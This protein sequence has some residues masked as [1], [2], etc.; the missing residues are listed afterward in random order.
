MGSGRF[1]NEHYS[2]ASYIKQPRMR[3]Y[4]M[5]Y[6]YTE[7][8]V[9]A[10]RLQVLY[11][12]L[13]KMLLSNFMITR[14]KEMV[15]LLALLY[16]ASS[17]GV[18]VGKQSNPFPGE[19]LPVE[20]KLRLLNKPSVKSIQSEDGDIIDCVDLY[21]QPAL[22]HPLLKNHSIR[23]SPSF[24]PTNVDSST[25]SILNYSL[26][27][28]Q[29]WH[30][31]G[32]C[33]DGTIPIR[34]VLK[35][36]LL[37]ASSL[38][39]YGRKNT[40]V[41]TKHDFRMLEHTFAV[42]IEH[43]HTAA[44]LITAG[45]SY[46]GAKADI[47]VWNPRVEADN[48]Y[49]TAQIWLRNG[50][51]N[52]SDTIEFGWIVNPS[53][54]GDRQTRLFIYW[55]NDSGKSTGCFDLL[56]PGFVQVNK[57]ILLGGTIYPT[58]AIHGQQ[59]HISL[60]VVRDFDQNVWWLISRTDNIMIGY[61]PCDIFSY[62]YNI[63]VIVEWGGDVYSP[64]MHQEPH[65]ATAMGSSNFASDHWSFACFIHQ[66]RIRDYSMTYKYPY[67]SFPFT[68]DVNCY[69]GENYAEMLFTEPLFYFGG[70]GRNLYCP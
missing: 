60:E 56:C 40:N 25:T 2:M 18:V 30:R 68:P 46:I 34:R 8:L 28:S 24:D 62:L 11:I 9:N 36:H 54:Y 63:A 49:S 50:P 48:E 52:N 3:D 51:F 16:I 21:K 17:S 32:S 42:G 1:A 26:P 66:P 57:D 29:V 27:F 70:P 4:S 65:T 35:H 38:E 61:W 31:S 7:D 67:P 6:K 23:I 45:Y 55:T 10:S 53:V 5:T 37:N 14:V 59:Y 69:S 12:L 20:E 41:I 58:S 15:I 44:A 19:E 47:N 39:R 64:R 43:Y 22:D 13:L 33:P